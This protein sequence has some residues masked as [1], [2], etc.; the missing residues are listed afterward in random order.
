MSD[1]PHATDAPGHDPAVGGDHHTTTDHGSDHGH[2]DHGLADEWEPGP[3]DIAAWGAG[4]LGV[5]LGLVVAACFAL[6]TAAVQA[7]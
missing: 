7:G 3:I 5:G 1:M 4:A 2:D 6:A